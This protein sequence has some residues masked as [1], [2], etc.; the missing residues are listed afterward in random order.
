MTALDVH[1]NL[2]WLE[3][4]RSGETVATARWQRGALVER[5]G[6]LSAS[7][8]S[9]LEVRIRATATEEV[10]ATF[11]KAYDSRGVDV[12]Q[13]D[14]MLERSP[15]ERLRWCDAGRSSVMRLQ[16]NARSR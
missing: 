1:W 15:A 4:T 14:R 13:I 10:A 2:E 11:V 7:E 5:R 6:S 16:R 8:W 9:E 3:F 12:A